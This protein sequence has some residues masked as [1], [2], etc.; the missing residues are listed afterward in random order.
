[1]SFKPGQRPPHVTSAHLSLLGSKRCAGEVGQFIGRRFRAFRHLF[2]GA[3]E[4]DIDEDPI[5]VGYK[6]DI[7]PALG[8]LADRAGRFCTPRLVMRVFLASRSI[9]GSVSPGVSYEDAFG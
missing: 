5:P 4:T 2:A 9:L 8:P 3:V 6:A 7:V 1:M